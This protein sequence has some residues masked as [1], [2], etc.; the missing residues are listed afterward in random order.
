MARTSRQKHRALRQLVCSGCKL[1][2]RY[3]D[4]RAFGPYAGG[5]A[6]KLK[7]D[8]RAERARRLAKKAGHLPHGNTGR[9]HR[10]Q[11]EF[12]EM[13]KGLAAVRDREIH[14]PIRKGAV[15]GNMFKTK[16][17]LWKQFT[18]NCPGATEETCEQET[19]HDR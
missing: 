10:G 9:Y 3:A 6:P 11:Q 18:E 19:L 4:F 5:F 2:C 1:H 15:L 12:A 8:Y 14:V 17:S 16:M 13:S 7:R